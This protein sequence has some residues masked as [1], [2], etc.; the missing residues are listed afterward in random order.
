[1][2]IELSLVVSLIQKDLLAQANQ[3]RYQLIY[4]LLKD[5]ILAEQLPDDCELPATRPLAQR[6]GLSRSTIIKAYELLKLEGLI[7]SRAGASHVVQYRLDRVVKDEALEHSN[8]EYVAISET[9]NSFYN[10]AS[11]LNSIDDEGVAFRPGV[12][13]LDLF[14]IEKWQKLQ[15]EYWQFVR[16]SDLG[17][18][19]GAGIEALR[20]TI[21][22]YLKLRRGLQC[23]FRQIFVVG[24]SLQSLYLIANL[25]TDPGDNVLMEDPTFPNVH[26]LFRGMRATVKGIPLDEEGMSLR[27]LEMSIS[28]K[29]KLLHLTPSC[30]YP[31][32]TQTSTQRKRDLLKLAGQKGLYVVEN[33]YEHE[34][35]YPQH[36]G[37]TL[38]SLDQ[39]ERTFYLSTFNRT[40]HPS[41]RVGFVVVPKHLVAPFNALIMHSHRSISPVLQTVLRG[42]IEKKYL[43]YHLNNVAKQAQLRRAS[44]LKLLADELGEYLEPIYSPVSSLHLSCRLKRGGDVAKVQDLLKLGIIAHPLSK[45]YVND[46]KKQGLIF[47]YSSVRPQLLNVHFQHLVQAFK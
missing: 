40:L 25:L 38:F 30:H 35:N 37:Q 39:Q 44:F 17:Y 1:M 20:R 45:C 26:S 42:F 24:G 4:G 5:A 7:A 10:T 31:L 19:S 22:N 43:H 46:A 23:D 34:I 32:G 13:P 14:P 11:R 21:V 12:P 27:H 36:N 18:Q 9:G 41:I 8:F 15:N 47:G 29:S 28:E 2:K 3:I 33:D 16:A 6:L